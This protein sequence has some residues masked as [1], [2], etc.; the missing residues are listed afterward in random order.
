MYEDVHNVNATP[1]M[2]NRLRYGQPPV[3][4]NYEDYGRPYDGGIKVIKNN[5]IK[6]EAFNFYRIEKAP[7]AILT[8]QNIS[9]IEPMI[10]YCYLSSK[11]SSLI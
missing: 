3:Q 4:N 6:T 8:L 1:E 7:I 11:D 9:L 2:Y 5:Y 10:K